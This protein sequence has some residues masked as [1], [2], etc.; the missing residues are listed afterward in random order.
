[1]ETDSNDQ[2][3]R[4]FGEPVNAVDVIRIDGPHEG[5]LHFGRHLLREA[6]D[7]ADAAA[8][9]AANPVPSIEL[10]Q[11]GGSP[12]NAEERR[13]LVAAWAEARRAG[14]N[15][16]VAYTNQNIEVRTH[17]QAEIGRASCRGRA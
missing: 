5:I 14:R 8:R 12:L 11:T 9:A 17:G 2:L 13:E 10:H 7:V 15:G 1:A 16:G 6:I 4:A 3:I